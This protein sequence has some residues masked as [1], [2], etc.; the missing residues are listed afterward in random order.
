MG[1][2]ER[3]GPAVYEAR[4]EAD[5]AVKKIRAISVTDAVLL[6]QQGKDVVVCGNDLASNRNLAG[7]VEKQANGKWRRCPPHASAGPKA[8]PHYQPV[9]R[10]PSGHTFYETSRR[11]AFE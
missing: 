3:Q 11:K 9:F 7:S 2:S 10:G 5:G 6:R 8:L 1:K 4:L